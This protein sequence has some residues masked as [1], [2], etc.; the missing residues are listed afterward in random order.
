MGEAWGMGKYHPLSENSN[1][2]K[3][4]FDRGYQKKFEHIFFEIAKSGILQIFSLIANFIIIL[5]Y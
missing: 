5:S 4:W 1:F 3:S 2:P